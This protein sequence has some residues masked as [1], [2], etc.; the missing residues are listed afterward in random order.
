[1]RPAVF[2]LQIWYEIDKCRKWEER[3]HYLK[4]SEIRDGRLDVVAIQGS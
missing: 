1:M 2:S 4:S 3:S